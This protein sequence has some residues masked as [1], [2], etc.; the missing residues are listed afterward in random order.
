MSAQEKADAA[1]DAAY[2]LREAMIQLAAIGESE[3]VN[4]IE[5]PVAML[6][7]VQRALNEEADRELEEM[8]DELNHDYEE[9]AI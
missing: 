9:A 6:D 7:D 2:H 8:I 5:L 1:W 3:L 4:M